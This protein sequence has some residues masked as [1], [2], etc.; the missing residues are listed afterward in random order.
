MKS[1]LT[2]LL[3][4]SLLSNLFAAPMVESHSLHSQFLDHRGQSEALANAGEFESPLTR[5]IA[6][7]AKSTEVIHLIASEEPITRRKAIAA[8]SIAAVAAVIFALFVPR[9]VRAAIAG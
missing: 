1:L 4:L 2:A 3:S 9:P 6:L 7:K 8:G 5:G